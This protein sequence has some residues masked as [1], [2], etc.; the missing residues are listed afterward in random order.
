MERQQCQPMNNESHTTLT[1]YKDAK[2]PD[3]TRLAAPRF[4]SPTK[5][6]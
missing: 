2:L 6:A 4:I 1:C 5:G 3:I